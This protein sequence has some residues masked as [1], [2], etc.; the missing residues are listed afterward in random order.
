LDGCVAAGLPPPRMNYVEAG[1]ELDAYW[2][3]YRFAVELDIY[4]THGT[5]ESFE[6]DRERQEDLLLAGISMS[7]VTGHRLA[8][9]PDEVIRRVARLLRQR[10]PRSNRGADHLDSAAE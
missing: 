1:F 9:E 10:T 6:R 4:E 3:E 7:R 2:P 5:R 8:R